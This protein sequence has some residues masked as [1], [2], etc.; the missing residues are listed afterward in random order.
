[1]TTTSLQGIEEEEQKALS[2][3]PSI[4]MMM[5]EGHER[6]VN[7]KNKEFEWELSKGARQGGEDVGDE[8]NN[9]QGRR[10]LVITGK[11]LGVIAEDDNNYDKNIDKNNDS[12]SAVHLDYSSDSLRSEQGRSCERE[13]CN[14]GTVQPF[15]I[16]P[17]K[18]G[19]KRGVVGALGQCRF[20]R[21]ASVFDQSAPILKARGAGLQ[22]SVSDVV[23]AEFPS[24]FSDS[25]SHFCRIFS[26]PNLVIY[27]VQ[28]HTF[29]RFFLAQ[30]WW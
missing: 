4:H 22:R 19:G 16:L 7:Q 5:E 9:E 27:L 26:R 8:G 11:G 23:E 25:R 18:V 6:G 3:L 28:G 21:S 1:M 10:E 30:I 12:D 17:S 24:P 20:D 15:E 14:I 29:D 13:I 2:K